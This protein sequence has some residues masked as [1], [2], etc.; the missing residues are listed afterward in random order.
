MCLLTPALG[1]RKLCLR[2]Q[3]GL[4]RTSIVTTVEARGDRCL[5]AALRDLLVVST[6]VVR[7]DGDAVRGGWQ[8]CPPL[9]GDRAPE[10][11]HGSV[12]SPVLGHETCDIMKITQ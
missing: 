1:G 8:K 2:R 7:P 3:V 5:R 4:P 12:P 9:R 10:P 11:G 6:L